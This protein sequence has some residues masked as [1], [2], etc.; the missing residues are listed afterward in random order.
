MKIGV[1]VKQVADTAA[2]IEL[3]PDGAVKLD[4]VQMVLNPYDEYAV[5]E[6]IKIKEAKG[7]EV[8]VFNIGPDGA[9][10]AVKTALAMGA[11]KAVVLRDPAQAELDACGIAE[12]LS[13]MIGREEYDLVI[14]GKQAVDSDTHQVGPSV[15]AKL[16]LPAVTFI[17]SCEVADGSVVVGRDAEG[18]K[19]TMELS[20]P[21]LLTCQK[22]LNEPRYPSLPGIMQAARKPKEVLTLADLGMEV[23]AK[24]IRKGYDTPPPRAA[25]RVL[26]GEIPDQVKELVQLLRNEARAV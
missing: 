6:A 9:D 20:F 15:A 4:G 26:S 12:A 21:A 13:K 10:E 24:V 11:D 5:E 16:G 22:G 8:V 23:R 14:C 19:E 7:G 3:T 2:R 17:T 18:V 25:G 1:L